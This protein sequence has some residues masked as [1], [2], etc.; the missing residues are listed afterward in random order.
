MVIF[1]VNYR[2][3]LNIYGLLFRHLYHFSTIYIST[4]LLCNLRYSSPVYAEIP[5][6]TF[7]VHQLQAFQALCQ[8]KCLT[9]KLSSNVSRNSKLSTQNSE[10]ETRNSIV[11]Y[12]PASV[13]STSYPLNQIF[14]YK[15][16][17]FS[18]RSF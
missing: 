18:F 4:R 13:F 8:K 7:M 16:S 12:F 15:F 5:W 11:N 6:V 10:P 14:L 3:P 17:H 9:W 2:R 1:I